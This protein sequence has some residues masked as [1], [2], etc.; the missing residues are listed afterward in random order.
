MSK[1]TTVLT[2]RVTPV[3]EELGYELVD[4][5]YKKEGTNWYLRIFIDSEQGIGLE[6]CQKVSRKLDSLLDE[7]DIIPN[8]YFLE[9]SSPGLERPIRKQTDYLRFVGQNVKIKTHEAIDSRKKFSGEILGIVDGIVSL[10]V[11]D[12]TI[13]IPFEKIASAKLVF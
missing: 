8:A 1:I 5:E 3:V 10:K 7:W 2:E 6:D 4:I 11:D 9:L 13:N 12:A